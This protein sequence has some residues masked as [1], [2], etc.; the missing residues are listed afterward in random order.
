MFV[1]HGFVAALLGESGPGPASVGLEYGGHASLE[2]ASS[3]CC[4][5]AWHQTVRV[6]ILSAASVFSAALLATQ[7]LAPLS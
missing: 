3:Y 4:C 2:A 6:T 1:R 7:G 5:A